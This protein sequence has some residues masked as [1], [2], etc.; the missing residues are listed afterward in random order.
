MVNIEA[1][2]LPSQALLLPCYDWHTSDRGL[3]LFLTDSTLEYNPEDVSDSDRELLMSGNRSFRSDPIPNQPG[4]DLHQWEEVIYTGIAGVRLQP[5]IDNLD[6]EKS[7]LKAYL[8]D[9]KYYL[10]IVK[11]EFVANFSTIGLVAFAENNLQ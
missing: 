8:K 10:F 1:G 3:E 7:L 4:F 9:K 6:A 5:L 2:K 11:S